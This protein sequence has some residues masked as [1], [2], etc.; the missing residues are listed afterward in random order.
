MRPVR[1][2]VSGR[3]CWKHAGFFFSVFHLRLSVLSI[4]VAGNLKLQDLLCNVQGVI[5]NPQRFWIVKS[6]YHN[7]WFLTL[8]GETRRSSLVYDMPTLTENQNVTL[9]GKNVLNCQNFM[10][11]KVCAIVLNGT[12][13]RQLYRLRRPDVEILTACLNPSAGF[14]LEFNA[15]RGHGCGKFSSRAAKFS[16]LLRTRPGHAGGKRDCFWLAAALGLQPM[17]WQ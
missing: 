11:G 4:F 7:S 3:V 10:F 14:G 17:G 2:S 9:W 6:H 15:S 5:K 1:A 12:G 16:A 8:Q 13:A